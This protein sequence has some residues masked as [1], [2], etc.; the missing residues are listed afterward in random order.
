M[1]FPFT[2]SKMSI[3]VAV[4]GQMHVISNTHPGFHDIYEHLKGDEHD[5]DFLTERLNLA[6]RISRLTFRYCQDVLG[7]NH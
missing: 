7:R 2:A 6:E 5:A 4:N 3:S 1:K